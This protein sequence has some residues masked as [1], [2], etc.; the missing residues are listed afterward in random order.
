MGGG[1]YTKH[2]K[3]SREKIQLSRNYKQK[4]LQLDHKLQNGKEKGNIALR[5]DTKEHLLE[6]FKIKLPYK[7]KYALNLNFT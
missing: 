1:L 7:I 2:L 6:E 3:Y 4:V 5:K